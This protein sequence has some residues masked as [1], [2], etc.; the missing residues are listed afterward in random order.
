MTFF[1][2]L[3]EQVD[4][5]EIQNRQEVMKRVA[6]SIVSL[7]SQM[8]MV[9]MVYRSACKQGCE[10]LD[11]EIKEDMKIIDGQLDALAEYMKEQ[12]TKRT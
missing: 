10:K 11:E 5:E 2:P 7:K 12:Q 3:N 6:K 8:S 4:L 1:R 9:G